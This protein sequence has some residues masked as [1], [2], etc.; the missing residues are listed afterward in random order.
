MITRSNIIGVTGLLC[1]GLASSFQADAV[2]IN[3]IVYMD[4]STSCQ[5]SIPTVTSAIRPRATG[6]RNEGPETAFVICGLSYPSG[7]FTGNENSASIQLSSFD[8]I[9]D[10]VSCTGV[11]RQSSGSGAVFVP[12]ITNV[13]ASGSVTTTWDIT[14]DF[15]DNG[16]FSWSITCAL[17]E[18]V[19]I[20]GLRINFDD[21]VGA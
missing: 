6:L 21:E 5:L 3:K 11:N 20:T 17:P 19:Q 16:G 7:G 12:K 14:A 18:G 15:G 4:P 8:G 1:V 9:A 13:G 2:T 10:T